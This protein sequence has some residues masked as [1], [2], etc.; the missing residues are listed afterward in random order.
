TAGTTTIKVAT[1]NATATPSAAVAIP[2]FS[3]YKG[4]SIGMS[5]DEVRAHLDH[6]KEKG[7]V[8][9]FFVFSD[10]ESAQVYYDGEGKVTAISVNYMGDDSNAPK[11]AAVLGEEI[12]AKPDGSMYQLIRYLSAGY[13][14]AYS[15]T[16][17]SDP[18]ITVTM[19]KM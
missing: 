9:D 8:Q 4:V 13:W 12:Q 2:L 17:G 15:R 5:A 18:I 16:A 3:N 6:L 19:Q 7:K 10:S 1:G 11:P 14:V